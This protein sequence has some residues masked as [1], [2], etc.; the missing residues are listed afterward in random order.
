MSNIAIPN[1]LYLVFMIRRAMAPP[2]PP[3]KPAAART[4]AAA[5]AEPV[6]Q[7]QSQAE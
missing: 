4:G 2:P 5:K 1:W 6:A 7:T 3:A